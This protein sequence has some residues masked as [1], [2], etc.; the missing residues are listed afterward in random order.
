MSFMGS[1][2][3][4]VAAA[5]GGAALLA[6]A[7]GAGLALAPGGVASA[8]P[9]PKPAAPA[10]KP[11]AHPPKPGAPHHPRGILQRADH[12][13][14][15]VKIKGQWVTLSLDRGKIASASSGSITLD[16]PDGQ[17][18]TIALG[19]TTHY[20]GV[21]HSAKTLERGD[22]AIVIS[23]AGT[24]RTVIEHQPGHHLPLAP[25]AAP[26]TNSAAA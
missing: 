4:K 11:G 26:S 2:K 24:A 10:A 5:V 22:V 3:K 17:P 12:A 19:P 14:A 15:E 20:R 9:A 21:A 7:G 23:Q 8:A 16:R 1:T 25:K 18:V 6:V 13:T